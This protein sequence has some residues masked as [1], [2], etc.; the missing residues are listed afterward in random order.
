MIPISQLLFRARLWFGS[1]N[2]HKVC[3]VVVFLFAGGSNRLIRT[4]ITPGPSRCDA[5]SV[6]CFVGMCFLVL[7]ARALVHLFS[8]VSSCAISP[9][10]GFEICIDYCADSFQV[11]NITISNL[12]HS[13]TS[14]RVSVSLEISLQLGTV[15][16]M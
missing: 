15:N 6:V 14:A 5:R 11:I 8:E 1:V 10:F 7:T 3:T 12:L 4:V 2:L 9:L 13:G 16:D